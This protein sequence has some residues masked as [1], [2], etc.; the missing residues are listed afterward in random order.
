MASGA[1]NK[2]LRRDNH[3]G[4]KRWRIAAVCAAAG[5]S[6]GMIARRKRAQSNQ[7]APAYPAPTDATSSMPKPPV[8]DPAADTPTIS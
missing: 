7:S 5:V 6:V 1:V 8:A 3:P 2:A 4:R